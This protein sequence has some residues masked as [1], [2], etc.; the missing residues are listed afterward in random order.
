MSKE[1]DL[2]K[3]EVEKLKRQQQLSR[4]SSTTKTVVGAGILKPSPPIFEKPMQPNVEGPSIN[5]HCSG[6]LGTDDDE[7]H[8]DEHVATSN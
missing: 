3:K 2:L 8:N 1:N 6:S 7:K 5:T 4:P